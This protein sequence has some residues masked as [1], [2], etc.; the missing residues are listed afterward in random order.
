MIHP[1]ARKFQVKSQWKQTLKAITSRIQ[2][3]ALFRRHE[4]TRSRPQLLIFAPRLP[5]PRGKGGNKNWWL[6]DQTKHIQARSKK[7]FWRS[8]GAQANRNL[9]SWITQPLRRSS[10]TN[11]LIWPYDLRLQKKYSWHHFSKI[12]FLLFLPVLSVPF[13]LLSAAFLS[14]CPAPLSPAQPCPAPKAAAGKSR[15]IKTRGRSHTPCAPSEST[16]AENIFSPSDVSRPS[17]PSKHYKY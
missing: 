11:D 3:W 15:R 6:Q 14:H 7:W 4:A 2:I 12:S 17:V 16:P 9:R 10:Y 8:T 13:G 5:N 1:R